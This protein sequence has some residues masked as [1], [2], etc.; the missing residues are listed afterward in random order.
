M[1]ARTLLGL[2]PREMIPGELLAAVS[3]FDSPRRV[4]EVLFEHHRAEGAA[5]CARMVSVYV[6]W[7]QLYGAEEAALLATPIR[8]IAADGIAADGVADSVEDPAGV[9]SAMVARRRALSVKLTDAVGVIA[10]TLRIGPAAAD[11]AVDCA[12]GFVERLPRVFA[13]VGS[14]RLAVSHGREL[15]SRSR[16][17]SAE[18]VREFD[19]RIAAEVD[20]DAVRG[21]ALPALRERADH[22]VFALD[23]E[24]AEQ[25]R[26]AA[27]R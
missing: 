22:L 21:F 27:E 25:R 10:A 13:L 9:R 24:A 15:L 23:P 12:I 17:L 7:Q 20:A 26:R 11:H 6:L 5:F 18:K 19:A 14:G 16:A 1:D 8:G 3:A 2:L 4:R